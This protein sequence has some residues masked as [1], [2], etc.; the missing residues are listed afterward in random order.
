MG[1]PIH[2]VRQAPTGVRIPDGFVTKLCFHS[3]PALGVWEKQVK[4]PGF[5]GGEMIDISTMFNTLYHT[6]YPRALIKVDEISSVCGYDPDAIAQLIALI[7]YPD[8]VSIFYPDNTSYD[9]FACLRRVEFSEHQ[10]G[11]FP[12]ATL[13]IAPMMYD[14]NAHVEAA[15]VLTAAVGT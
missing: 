10:E 6:M 9:I 2:T 5:D 3:Q 8:S 13:T 7:N 14:A 15:G 4:P 12:T 11:E 1:V